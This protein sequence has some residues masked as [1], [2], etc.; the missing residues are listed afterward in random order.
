MTNLDFL[1]DESDYTEE[2]MI[3][4]ISNVTKEINYLGDRVRN[5]LKHIYL[6]ILGL[7]LCI[8]FSITTTATIFF[9]LAFVITYLLANSNFVKRR[10]KIFLYWFLIKEYKEKKI[11]TKE[12][13]NL[14][15]K[16]NIEYFWFEN[17]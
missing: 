11:L 5:Y 14:I 2:K 13:K 10:E 16:F 3:S 8:I 7:S 6:Q 17:R 15:E 4:N 1:F 12:N 9:S